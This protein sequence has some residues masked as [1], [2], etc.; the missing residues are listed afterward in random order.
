MNYD[1]D[2]FTII[3]MN[4]FTGVIDMDLIDNKGYTTK[5]SGH[6]YGLSLVKE[7]VSKYDN[8]SNKRII[9][10]NIFKQEIN[11]DM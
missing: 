4:N 10:R 2:K 7:L 9:T 1:K 6:G 5:N 11:I 3:M 8:I